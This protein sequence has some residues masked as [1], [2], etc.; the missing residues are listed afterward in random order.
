MRR[1]GT[2]GLGMG[3][4][5]AS[6]EIGEL[7][8]TTG[9]ITLLAKQVVY[10]LLTARARSRSDSGLRRASIAIGHALER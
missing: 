5:R 2:A 7:A 3:Y 8:S 4:L 10:G 9:F 6:T 1:G